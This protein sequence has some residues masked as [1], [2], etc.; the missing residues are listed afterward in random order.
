[1]NPFR[2]WLRSWRRRI[3]LALLAVLALPYLLTFAYNV[4]PPPASALMLWQWASDGIDYRW[5]PLG[6]ISAHLVRA[7]FTSEDQRFCQHSGIDWRELGPQLAAALS[8]DEGRARGASTIPMQVAKNL[9]LWPSRS[10]VRK[11]LE[12]PLALWIDLIW[13]KRRVMEIY[14]NIAE[15]GPGVYGA[16]AAARFHFHKPASALTRYE[17]A[18]LAAALPNPIARPAGRPRRGL[19]D[20]ALSIMAR[21]AEALP[22]MDCLRAR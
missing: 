10:R 16:E 5:R 2:R 19:H 7:V 21:E 18:L 22:Y 9:Y 6:K 15:W 4:V 12:M 1:V 11:A 13:T 20:L 8:E 3:A 17:A 14:L